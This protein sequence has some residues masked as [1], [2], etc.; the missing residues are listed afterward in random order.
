MEP[1][2]VGLEEDLTDGRRWEDQGAFA[3]KTFLKGFTALTEG[4]FAGLCRCMQFGDGVVQAALLD[5]TRV[6]F[7]WRSAALV[8]HAGQGTRL[9]EKYGLVNSITAPC[10]MG[11]RGIV[12]APVWQGILLQKSAVRCSTRYAKRLERLSLGDCLFL[13]TRISGERS[14][15]LD[16]T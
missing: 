7:G 6:S 13:P 1:F 4:L 11:Y 16:T 5:T 12:R 8:N 10:R 14:W 9:A 3:N 2:K 15:L